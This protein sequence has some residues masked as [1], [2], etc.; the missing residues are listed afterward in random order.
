MWENKE[1]ETGPQ[2]TI[3][4]TQQILSEAIFGAQHHFS[5][6]GLPPGQYPAAA[7]NTPGLFLFL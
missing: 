3:R 6:A 1:R 4:V 2:Q 7:E 5:Q